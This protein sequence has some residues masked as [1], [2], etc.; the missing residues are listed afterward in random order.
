MG[1]EARRVHDF[2]CINPLEFYGSMVNEDPQEFVEGI[3][4]IVDIMGIGLV[5]KSAKTSL[6]IKEMDISRLMTHDEQ[7]DDEKLKESA[8]EA[9]RARTDSGSSFASA[10]IPKFNKD[11][12][13]FPTCQKYGKNH[14]GECM[15]DKDGCYRC[16]EIGHKM[17]DCLTTSR[18]GREMS[19]SIS[20]GNP[21][22]EGT[23]SDPSSG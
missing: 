14:Q 6:L 17:R 19:R 16:G 13:P 21:T 1:T 4:K 9:K 12:H 8:R 3:Y 22:Q 18:R 7:I 15:A 2:T 11:R 20:L 5:E 10:P 23:S